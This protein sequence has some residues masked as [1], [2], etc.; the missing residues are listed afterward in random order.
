MKNNRRPDR[1]YTPQQN[2]NEQQPEQPTAPFRSAYTATFLASELTARL[3]AIEEHRQNAA[4]CRQQAE[5]QNHQIDA[6]QQLI[7][8]KQREIQEFV[9][10]KE[11]EITSIR[12]EIERMRDAERG[13]QAEAERELAALNEATLAVADL[14]GLLQAHAPA[15]LTLTA[16]TATQDPN[17]T[18]AETSGPQSTVS[19]AFAPVPGAF[20]QQGGAA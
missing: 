7:G 5:D 15:A 14:E 12:A 9:A 13:H 1:G 2:G 3:H 18:R 19:G 17:A 8:D 6:R 20:P 10:E 16:G 11:R 4:R